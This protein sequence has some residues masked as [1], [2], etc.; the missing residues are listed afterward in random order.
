MP[1]NREIVLPLIGG[2]GNQ[3]FS[4]AAA[5]FI[6]RKTN[7]VVHLD[8]SFQVLAE[9]RGGTVRKIEIETLIPK[10]IELRSR[11]QVRAYSLMFRRFVNKDFWEQEKPNTDWKNLKLDPR[12][13]VYYGYFQS[14][15]LVDLVI[16]KLIEQFRAS[17][18]FA[19][20][21]Q[22]DQKE[23]IAV[24]VRLGDKMSDQQMKFYGPT[25]IDYYRRAIQEAGEMTKISNV[26][27]HTDDAEAGI[28]WLEHLSNSLPNFQIYQSENKQFLDDLASLVCSRVLVMGCSSFSWWA[29][30]L[31]CWYQDPLVFVPNPW[32]LSD[33]RVDS[34]L[35]YPRWQTM[36]KFKVR[37]V[38]R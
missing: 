33:L 38:A 21:L 26:L 3:L 10:G 28:Q 11:S 23:V 32:Q 30:R 18:E 5:M 25:S 15:E 35:N 31:A 6:Q 27:I 29:A 34:D 14:W 12:V 1:S 22:H 9:K 17:S 24:H 7:R 20:V 8:P 37:V 16:D 4:L 2:F 19:R 13:G 36:N